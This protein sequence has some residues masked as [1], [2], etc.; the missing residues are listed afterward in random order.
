[1][2]ALIRL[3]SRIR[4]ARKAAG[5]KTAKSFLKKHKVPA[6]TYSQ[7]ESGARTADDVALKFYSKVF[8]VSFD[9]LKTGKG[10]PFKKPTPF[11]SETL[12]EESVELKRADHI[13]EVLLTKILARTIKAHGEKLSPKSVK[14][15]AEKTARNYIN[16]KKSKQFFS[17]NTR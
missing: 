17:N 10:Q 4:A 3:S 13:N 16:H 8:D 7:H 5:F 11:K 6:S 15:I 14:L 1:M 12:A 2:T 9:W